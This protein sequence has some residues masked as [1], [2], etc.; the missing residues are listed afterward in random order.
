MY[1]TSDDNEKTFLWFTIILTEHNLNANI[2]DTKKHQVQYMLLL[3]MLLFLHLSWPYN[4]VYRLP[5]K[6]VTA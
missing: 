1:G 3:P 2:L 6:Q 4:H 5:Q